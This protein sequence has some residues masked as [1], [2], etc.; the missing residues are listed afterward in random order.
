MAAAQAQLCGAT[1][2]DSSGGGGESATD[3]DSDALAVASALPLCLLHD[4]V[5]VAVFLAS[6]P[7]HAVYLLIFARGLASL[8]AFF[9]P[10]LASTSLLLAV[11]ATAGP[12]IG[13][14]AEWP[15][16]RSLGRTCGIAVASLCA[17]LRPDGSGA[18]AGLVGQLCSFV[19]G[20]TDAAS[21][22]RVEEIMGEPCDTTASC[23][24]LDEDKSLLLLG[25]D[26]CKELAFEVPTMGGAI[27]ERS[28][29]DYDDFGDLK[30]EIDDKVVISE[31]LKVSDSWAEQCCPRGTLF[32]QEIEAGEQEE[33][34]IQGQGLILSAIDEIS[35]SV[36]EKRLE[37]DPVSVE[38]KKSEPVQALEIKKLK[39]VE[40]VVAKILEIKKPEPAHEVQIKKCESMRPMQIKKSEPVESVE[41]KKPEPA[42]S[43]E[44]KNSKPEQT[45]EIKKCEPVQALEV[46]KS[47]PVEPVE[48]KKRERVKP[49]SSIAQR[50]KLW[51][52]QVSGN[53]K[54]VLEDKE[55]SSVEFSLE[56]APIKDVKQCV[57]FEGDPCVD[58]RNNEQ[59]AQEVA[60]SSEESTNEQQ[61]QEVKDV[62]EYTRS[63]TE[64]SSEKCSQN[65]EAEEIAHAVAQAEEKLQQGGKDAQPE[66]ELQEQAHKI[67]QPEQELQEMEEEVYTDVTASPAMWNGR[68][69]PLKSTSI[70]GRVHSRTS[71]ENLVS[72]GSP[73]WKDKEWK[74][75][76]ACKLYEER[77]QL[78]LCRDRAVVEGSDNMDMLWEAYEVGS[79][80]GKGR[81]GKRSGSKAKG[82]ADNK[83]EEVVDE[84]EEEG[85][86]DGDEEE[87]S[88]RQLCCL[89]ALKF[90]T[91]KMN[92]GGGKPSLSKISKVLRR[93]T[94]LSRMGSRRKQSG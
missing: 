86:D 67:E 15:G 26:G 14:C 91:R 16:V 3:G 73:S 79:G 44:T 88:V 54:P 62:K 81:A 11:L 59:Q 75:T 83:V 17:G 69:S 58:K 63:E 94:A 56:K 71:S 76:L 31:D 50:I 47:E 65:T 32:V 70:A 20:P 93:M 61:E 90:S 46:R 23:F 27:G 85:E 43:L 10:L 2:T 28:F 12:Y 34:G 78:R 25:G 55:E 7:L 30:D 74:R 68:E 36:E 5:G 82:G 80:G 60:S 48:I 22:L 6:H 1:D 33:N 8:A 52:A 41:I 84:G 24:V 13:G 37:C 57:R 49:R 64:T 66:T 51:E 18:G 35:D 39:P 19:L 38:I 53:I 4:L 92:F 42:E 40:P 29:L 89:Q 77:M 9:W 87:G 21:V 72:E 45:V